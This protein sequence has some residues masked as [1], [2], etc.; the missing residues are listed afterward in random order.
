MVFY[1]IAYLDNQSKNEEQSGAKVRMKF[2]NQGA[3]EQNELY[4][5]KVRHSIGSVLMWLRR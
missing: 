4:D 1:I 5:L 2:V 3:R